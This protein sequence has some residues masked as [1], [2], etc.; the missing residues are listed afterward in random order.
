MTTATTVF[1]EESARSTAGTLLAS[2]PLSF[3]RVDEIT[4]AD[5]VVLSGALGWAHR[6]MTHVTNGAKGIIVLDPRPDDV[7]TIRELADRVDAEE[8]TVLLSEQF[9]G[10]PAVPGIAERLE[11]ADTLAVH[12][13]LTGSSDDILF[14]GLR[15][16]RSVGVTHLELVDLLR[17]KASASATLRGEN[18]RG[19]ILVRILASSTAVAP[20][21]LAL[22]GYGLGSI[23]T[24][25]LHDASTARPA[26][27]RRSTAD[28]V[29]IAP[30]RYET[31]HRATWRAFR[32]GTASVDLRAFA[33]DLCLLPR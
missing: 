9:S 32:A 16:V 25:T 13:M 22:R 14:D 18:K 33:E 8:T 2:L 27:V 6:A 28:G 21:A 5:A 20:S 30:T 24:A 12:G 4:S 1:L 23:V 10:N 19:P 11:G 15:L 3:S 17:N 29:D 26:T 7:A 31:A